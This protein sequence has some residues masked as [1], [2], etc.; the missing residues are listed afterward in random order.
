MLSLINLYYSLYV[1][2]IDRIVQNCN[3]ISSFRLPSVFVIR[4][5]YYY[6]ESYYI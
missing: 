3:E 4:T 5:Y 2:V 1:C 6:H